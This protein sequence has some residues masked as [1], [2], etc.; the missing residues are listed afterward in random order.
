[1]KG[2]ALLRQ[3]LPLVSV[4]GNCVNVHFG[5]PTVAGNT[6][7]CLLMQDEGKARWLAEH[8]TQTVEAAVEESVRQAAEVFARQVGEI[9]GDAV[10]E[11]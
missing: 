7:W 9:T 5:R 2:V 4:D 8:V 11:Q 10:K 1:M 3:H 6:G